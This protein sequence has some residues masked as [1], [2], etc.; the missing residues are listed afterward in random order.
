MNKFHS[1]TI[2]RIQQL[3]TD[4]VAIHFDVENND[5]FQFQAGQYITIKQ[6]ING[7][8]VRRAYSICSANNEGVAIGIKKVE[9]GKMSTFLTENVK[10]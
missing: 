10:T 2:S 9:G 5:L 4:A 8:Q 1:L 6:D 7:E 3:T